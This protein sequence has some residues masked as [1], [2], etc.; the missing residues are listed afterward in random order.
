MHRHTEALNSFQA[1]C[2]SFWKSMT[3]Y[4]TFMPVETLVEKGRKSGGGIFIKLMKHSFCS[5]NK[6]PHKIFLLEVPNCWKERKPMLPSFY[7]NITFFFIP[8]YGN[9]DTPCYNN[10]L[11]K[12]RELSLLPSSTVQFINSCILKLMLM[13]VLP[14]WFESLKIPLRNTWQEVNTLI[15]V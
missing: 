15:P 6:W 12:E 14:F 9:N 4:W 10:T 11:R 7:Q 5:S 1:P 8:Y 2:T 3:R 13:V